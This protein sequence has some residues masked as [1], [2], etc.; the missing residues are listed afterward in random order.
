MWIVDTMRSPAL[1]FLFS[2]LCFL[3][4]FT[5]AVFADD[6]YESDFQHVLLGTPQ[7]HTTFFHRPSAAS[8]A[9]LLYTL[10]EKAVLGAIN[11][12]DGSVVW[13]QLL[14]EGG[15]NGTTLEGYLRAGGA[16]DTIVSGTRGGV[17]A[18]DAA[19]GRLVWECTTL[20]KVRG[21]EVLEIV[22]LDKD[23]LVLSQRDDRNLVSRLSSV[24]GQI[25]WQFKDER[26]AS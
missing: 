14:K 8:K 2:V 7:P 26:S 22:G 13:R 4:P 18:W 5:S 10:S 20:G 15:D 16:K 19:D 12:K 25:V 21:L 9:S 6:A 1:T 24:S 17:R 3:T 11:P 23:V